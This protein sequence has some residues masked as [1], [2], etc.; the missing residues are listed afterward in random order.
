VTI[1]KVLSGSR[2]QYVPVT[3]LQLVA[4]ST[5]SALSSASEKSPEAFENQ[6]TFLHEVIHHV[7]TLSSS[8]LWRDSLGRLSSGTAVLLGESDDDRTHAAR[9]LL[10]SEQA[11]HYRT[12]G[13]SVADLCE[14]VAVLESFKGISSVKTVDEFGRFRNHYFPG[15]GNSVYRRTFDLLTHATNAATAFDLLAPLTW[16]ALQGDIPGR[17]FAMLAMDSAKV[18][19]A[20]GLPAQELLELFGYEFPFCRQSAL[21]KLHASERHPTLFP[22]L[23]RLCRD[24]PE[25]ELLEIFARPHVG[26][27]DTRFFPPLVY[28][29]HRLGR[30]QSAVWGIGQESPKLRQDI[31]MFTGIVFAAE[32]LVR[33]TRQHIPCP[34]EH[35]PNHAAGL[36]TG[37]FTPPLDP[38][39][40]GFRALVRENRGKELYEIA[41]ATVA[42]EPDSVPASCQSDMLDTLFPGAEAF[43]V[44]EGVAT[45]G[46]DFDREFDLD[47]VDNDLLAMVVCPKCRTLYQE[48]VSHRR[49]VS[50][51]AFRCECGELLEAGRDRGFTIK[52]GDHEE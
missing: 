33:K 50:G 45:L 48:W 16:L 8:Y 21:A 3:G 44:E 6:V 38:D 4:S 18:R 27:L 42:I 19:R 13:T 36:C 51:Y 2:A 22:I 34:H 43:E 17:S 41:Q 31:A 39:Q 24:V 37:W 52:M 30:P 28:G 12:F 15:K 49:H 46:E 1:V 10:R 5:Q 29:A 14:G 26:A 7:Q 47:P 9:E 23:E 20:V 35:C 40:C 25:K 11:F 32:Q